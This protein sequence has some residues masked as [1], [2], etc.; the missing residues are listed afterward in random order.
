MPKGHYR[1][2]AF[3]EDSRPV[4][5]RS[6][7]CNSELIKLEMRIKEIWI[8]TYGDR[9]YEYIMMRCT[10]DEIENERT[11]KGEELTDENIYTAMQILISRDDWAYEL[12]YGKQRQYTETRTIRQRNSRKRTEQSTGQISL[13]I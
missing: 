6:R 7:Y 4:D 8:A 10:V 3:V 5:P 11:R 9:E 13:I 2:N 12:A 1:Y